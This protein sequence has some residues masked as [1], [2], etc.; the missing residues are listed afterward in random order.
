MRA[1]GRTTG[2]A[3]NASAQQI[4]TVHLLTHCSHLQGALGCHGSGAAG[5]H[6]ADIGW[7]AGRLRL[8][9]QLGLRL[10]T[11]VRADAAWVHGAVHQRT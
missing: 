2:R 11:Q 9:W 10:L 7:H 3:E 8:P 6:R 5:C 4:G 1:Y